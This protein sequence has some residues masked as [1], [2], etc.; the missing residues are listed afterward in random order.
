MENLD[1]IILTIVIVF[2][3]AG[4]IFIPLLYAHK[5]EK[6]YITKNHLNRSCSDK[7]KFVNSYNNIEN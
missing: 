7:I 3:F 6:K 4:F 5:I 1:I 2:L